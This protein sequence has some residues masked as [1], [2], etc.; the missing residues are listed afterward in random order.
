MNYDHWKTTNPA[1]E[2]LGSQPQPG[3]DDE[4]GEPLCPV[5]SGDGRFLGNLGNRSFFRCQSCGL[6][7]SR[8]E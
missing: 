4:E 6:D 3:Q 2:E 8:P 7:F 1:D 5:C